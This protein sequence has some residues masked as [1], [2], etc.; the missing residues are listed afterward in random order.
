MVA[1]VKKEYVFEL[2]RARLLLVLSSINRPS[3]D[4]LVSRIRRSGV[5]S[6]KRSSV[7]GV[8][9]VSQLSIVL[10][11][12]TT[13]WVSGLSL[14][15][16]ENK[17]LIETVVIGKTT[18]ELTSI[19]PEGDKYQP[20]QIEPMR[21]FAVSSD[22]DNMIFNISLELD[23][24]PALVKAVI[25][26]ESAF[27]QFAVSSQ[28]ANGLMQLMPETAERFAVADPFNAEQ[29]IRGG[30]RFLKH[31]LLTFEND[32]RLAI[33][34]YNAGPGRVLYYR[35]VPPFVETYTFVYKV[36]GLRKLYADFYADHKDNSGKS[37]ASLEAS[38]ST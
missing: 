33:A 10:L 28:G 22:F 15:P 36:L 23:V 2:V 13:L 31:L 20:P 11:A 25:H 30:V 9:F 4:R 21:L 26:S 32:E 29:N 27:D 6:I 5:F 16:F 35:N 14:M 8:G 24:D 19:E 18:D 37:L 38:F 12:V 7:E 34:A 17:D 1:I 3:I